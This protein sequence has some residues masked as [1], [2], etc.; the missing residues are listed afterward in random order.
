[1]R[2]NVYSAELTKE[3]NVVSK[4]ADT[5]IEYFGIRFILASHERL[6]YTPEDDDRSAVTF[7]IPN[8]KSFNASDLAGVFRTAAEFCEDIYNTSERK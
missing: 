6:H 7:W 8:A 2:V 4:K 3:V 5:G 1:M